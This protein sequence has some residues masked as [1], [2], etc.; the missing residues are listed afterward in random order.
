MQTSITAVSL[1]LLLTP[2]FACV[3]EPLTFADE[4]LGEADDP[5]EQ[6]AVND[7]LR[8]ISLTV[9]GATKPAVIERA[10]VVVLAVDLDPAQIDR[11]EFCVDGEP[12]VASPGQPFE[13][14]WIA[15]DDSLNGPHEFTVTALRD[16]HELA[17]DSMIVELD[18]PRPGTRML[19]IVGGE[20]SQIAAT[21]TGVAMLSEDHVAQRDER[22][23]ERWRSPLPFAATVMRYEPG[24]D[25]LLIAGV[26]D[27][28]LT[29]GGL[30]AEGELGWET[31][32]EGLA[33]DGV[34][35]ERLRSE[36]SQLVLTGRRLHA[37]VVR[38]WAAQLE[39]DGDEVRSIWA[40]EF[41]EDQGSTVMG[42]PAIDGL[43][44]VYLPVTTLSVGPDQPWIR[45]T[46][47]AYAS[48]E[49]VWTVVEEGAHS[50]VFTA[51]GLGP[52]GAVHL[53]A[54]DDGGGQVAVFDGAGHWLD[55]HADLGEAVTVLEGTARGMVWAGTGDGDALA[56]RMPGE[57]SGEWQSSVWGY[58]EQGSRDLAVGA[59][60]YVY[61]LSDAP[62]N[63]VIHMLHP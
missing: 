54:Y 2:I 55:A 57:A 6:P 29:L 12:L 47:G 48:G 53:A 32:V 49:P 27:G 19:T 38:G 31:I 60:G 23:L 51:A 24:R 63:A 22:G 16:G 1:A 11:V 35:L 36:G 50:P 59:L 26:V 15:S 56:G 30:R 14:R 52:A 7:E 17:A 42:V 28:V 34:V 37:G 3:D 25:E 41:G 62:N 33:L 4:E 45:A 21:A 61:V 40:R 9:N 46:F 39:L 20:W 58:G 13:A 18:L 44:H 8:G 43:G 10:S 5:T